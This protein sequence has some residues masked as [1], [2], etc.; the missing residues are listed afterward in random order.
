MPPKKNDKQKLGQFMTTNYK[1]ILQNLFIPDDVK[2]I[3]EPFCGNGDLLNFVKDK[4]KDKD[5]YIIESYDIEPKK[6]FIIQ[7]D[8]IKNPPDFTNKFLLTNPPYLARNKCDEKGLY[9]KYDV[10]DFYKCHMKELLKNSPVGGILIIP[11]N[12]W[13]SIRKNDIIL[14]KEF[15]KKFDILHL[16]IFEEQVFS[17]TTYTVCSFQFQ[18]KIDSIMKEININIYPCGK[19]IKTILNEHNNFMIGGHIYNL[20]INGN[21]TINR[22]TKNNKDDANTNILVKCID[23]NEDNKIGLS[24]VD[25]KDVYVDNTPNLSARTYA[26]LIIN[27]VLNAGE[28]KKLVDKFNAYLNEEREKYHSLFLTNYRE[29]KD[30]ARKRISFDLVYK[31][32][33]YLLEN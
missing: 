2:N 3:I 28:Q 19:E 32:C 26:S 31:I 30:I 23:D 22:I 33:Q 10:N 7:R 15:L 17:D 11:L 8:T 5:K 9:D 4:D 1:Y 21:Y 29:S 6:E 18:L 14:R 25:K 12:F 24:I 20:K 13:S 16:N 27:P